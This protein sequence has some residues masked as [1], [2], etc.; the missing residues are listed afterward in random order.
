MRTSTSRRRRIVLLAFAL[1]ALF[2]A[3]CSGANASTD[4]L[5]TLAGVEDASEPE[6]SDADTVDP[7]EVDAEDALLN[8]AQCVRDAGIPKFPDP[9]VNSEGTA[10]FDIQGMIAIGIDPRSDD[11][12]DAIA[13]CQDLLGDTGFGGG[14]FGGA[15]QSERQDSLL[16]LASCMR[17]N[18]VAD[19]P[20]PDVTGDGG[21]GAGF[22]ADIDREDPIVAAALE[23]CQDEVN[24]PGLGGR[25]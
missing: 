5:P 2:A 25:S 22:F 12:Q 6:S 18:G 21:R 19:F 20:D 13:G 23:I 10:S 7:E 24:L 17:A 9:V 3:G 8:V 14:R 15:D 16:A 11:F 1:L 4:E